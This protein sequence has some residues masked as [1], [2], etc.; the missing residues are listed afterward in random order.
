MAPKWDKF[1]GRRQLLRPGRG[2]EECAE[3]SRRV[4]RTGKPGPRAAGSF[5]PLKATPL[6]GAPLK[7][8]PRK[9]P[10]SVA[11]G[12]HFDLLA[13]DALHGSDLRRDAAHISRLVALAA[14]RMRREE[15]S[16]GLNDD[17]IERSR[18]GRL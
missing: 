10:S 11:R 6:K 18:L 17:P 15:G 14:I 9:Q 5:V 16:V 13:V 8:T 2:S 1:R 4:R 3:P 12:D 7:A